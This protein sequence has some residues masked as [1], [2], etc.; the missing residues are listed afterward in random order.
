MAI[1]SAAWKNLS[2]SS[3]YNARMARA[4]AVLRDN[5]P[6]NLAQPV[7]SGPWLSSMAMLFSQ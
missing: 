6:G 3:I 2:F 5:G 1:D 7:D 4:E